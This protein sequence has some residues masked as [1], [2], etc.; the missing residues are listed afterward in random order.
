MY[1]KNYLELY[2]YGIKD[3]KWGIRR[4]QNEDGSL[5]DLG[6]ERYKSGVSSI[7]S[8]INRHRTNK[9]IRDAEIGTMSDEELRKE[10]NRLRL[11]NAYAK[12][13]STKATYST[14]T[15]KTKLIFETAAPIAM[16]SAAALALLKIGMKYW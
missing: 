13:I 2:H 11:E 8:N 4:Y 7:A 10:T 5:T 14:D 6:R 3:M 1:D 15:S 9:A 16:S 12:E